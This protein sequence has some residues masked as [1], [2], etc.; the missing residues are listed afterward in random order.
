MME[1]DP[2]AYITGLKKA[3]DLAEKNVIQP[4]KYITHYVEFWNI[5][6]ALQIIE[7]QA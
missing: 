2:Q 6:E 7:R 3:V 4:E 1:R 5:N